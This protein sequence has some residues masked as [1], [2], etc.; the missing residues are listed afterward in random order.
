LIGSIK[1][2]KDFLKEFNVLEIRKETEGRRLYRQL[3]DNIQKMK[4]SGE[5]D[6]DLEKQIK[7]K[8]A[9]PET[10]DKP[11]KIDKK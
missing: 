9:E 3:D 8:K 11:S 4:V 6:R 5:T 2:I 1:G 7:A 10:E